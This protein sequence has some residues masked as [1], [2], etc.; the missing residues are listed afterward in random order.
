MDEIVNKF[1]LSVDTYTPELYLR[2]QRFTYAACGLFTK[3]CERE[4]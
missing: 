2:Q 4:H 3:H 1:L